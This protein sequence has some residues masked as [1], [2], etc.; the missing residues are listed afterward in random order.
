ITFSQA[1]SMAKG[2][3]MDA[4]KSDIKLYRDTGK[5]ERDAITID[6]D[7]VLQ[8]KIQD[9]ELKDKDVI[10]VSSSGFKRFVGGL[11]GYFNFGYFGFSGVRPGTGL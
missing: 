2:L 11:A 4:T 10:I 8:G 6:Y 1:I 3:S 5:Q 9:I 7:D